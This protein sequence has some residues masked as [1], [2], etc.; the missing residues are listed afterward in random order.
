LDPDIKAL[1]VQGD[2]EMVNE[3]L[4]D[5]MNNE[6][7]RHEKMSRVSLRSGGSKPDESFDSKKPIIRKQSSK[8]D[9]TVTISD[10][11]PN[12]SLSE[13]TSLLDFFLTGLSR[14]LSLSP[15][16]VFYLYT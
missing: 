6:S 12:R 14:N 8:D 15:K 1:L 10:I 16:Q 7:Q 9:N 4:R 3:I 2:T 11:D 13:T 5:V